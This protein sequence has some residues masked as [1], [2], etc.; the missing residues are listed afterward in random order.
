MFHLY[1]Y[2]M[3]LFLVLSLCEYLY[4]CMSNRIVCQ[5]IMDEM[6]LRPFLWCIAMSSFIWVERVPMNDWGGTVSRWPYL[7]DGMKSPS[8][9]SHVD[10]SQFN[11]HISVWE[12]TCA[13]DRRVD[14]HHIGQVGEIP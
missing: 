5:I 10:I 4:H 12:S 6:E 14:L 13:G 11:M 8:N 9:V 1:V 2:E 7:I 3:H